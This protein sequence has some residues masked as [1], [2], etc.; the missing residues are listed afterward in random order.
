M[1]I[2]QNKAIVRRMF[3]GYNQGNLAIL[4]D[5]MAA[6]FVTHAVPPGMPPNGESQ[7]CALRILHTA[8]PDYHVTVEDMIA[9]GDK[10]MARLTVQGTQRGDFFG[11]PPTGMH[12]TLS[13]V[14][15]FR[16]VDGKLVEYWLSTD[17]LG[18]LQQLRASSTGDM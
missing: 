8:F 18:L 7:K 9:E 15:I 14:D 11:I 5:L 6:D 4:D 1:S 13:A 2:E 16:F 10:V 17:S 3:E 12:V